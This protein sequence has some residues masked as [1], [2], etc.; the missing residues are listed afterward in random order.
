MNLLLTGAFQY[1]EYQKQKLIDLGFVVYYMQ[2]E[3]D[4][5][6]IDASKIDAVVC[7]A[8]FL[9][10]NI[11]RFVQLKYIQLTSAG[12]DRVPLDKIEN[13]GITLFNARG[14]YSI[15]MAEWVLFRTL[16]HYKHAIH[17]RTAQRNALWSK[18][19]SLREICGTHVAIIGAGS[20]GREVAKRFKAFGTY[21]IGFDV[22]RSNHCEYFEEID[23]I[24]S[25][26]N[27]IGE[28][29]IVVVTAPLTPQTFHMISKSLILAMKHNAVLVN[30]ARGA[31]VNES[32]LCEALQIRKDIHA[33]LDVFE[34]EPLSVDSPLWSMP[35]VSISP[36]NS[37]VSDG[38]S[39]RMFNVIYNNL[40]AYI[41][42]I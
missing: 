37:F 15:P 19:R 27:R 2:Q 17:F 36:H 22:S 41:N 14:V 33:M 8:L 1:S 32:E 30:I 35:N 3:Q 29:D 6:P 42:K 13:R 10:H 40:S 16:E 24:D 28:F 34:V 21:N 39:I 25:I 7:N 9:Y 23:H 18:D 4:V 11:D 38:N 20:V 31:L 12:L 5:L 26:F